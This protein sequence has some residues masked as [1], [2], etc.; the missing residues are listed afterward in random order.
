LKTEQVMGRPVRE[1]LGLRFEDGADHV[2]TALEWEVR[3]QNKPVQVNAEGDLPAHAVAD[4]FPAYD[5]DEGGLLL[6]LTPVG[7][8]A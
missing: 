2:G 6:V 3:V 7:A 8:R 4:L 5:D 1:V